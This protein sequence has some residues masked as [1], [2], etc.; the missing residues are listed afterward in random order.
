MTA[1]TQDQINQELFQWKPDE[2]GFRSESICIYDECGETSTIQLF[3]KEYNP[4]DRGSTFGL[5]P[6]PF[7]I[8]A[9]C[10]DTK[11]VVEVDKEE[12]SLRRFY[13]LGVDYVATMYAMQ[14]CEYI[15]A[16]YLRYQTFAVLPHVVSLETSTLRRG[17]IP[18]VSD[19][20]TT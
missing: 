3:V 15:V 17:L 4:G 14:F 16:S 11:R 9:L 7:R 6:K 2:S 19:S 5:L 8:I 13:E 10:T 12:Y 20:K 1:I 18:D